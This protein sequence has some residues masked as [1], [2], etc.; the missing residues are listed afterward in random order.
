MKSRRE[1]NSWGIRRWKKVL[2]KQID[3]IFLGITIGNKS[4][5]K[6][7]ILCQLKKEI[8]RL[9]IIEDTLWGKSETK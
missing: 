6:K 9:E 4:T 5:K 8:E 3:F 2:N 1:T 7:Y